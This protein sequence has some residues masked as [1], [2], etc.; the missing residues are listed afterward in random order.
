[1][2]E[3]TEPGLERLALAPHERAGSVVGSEAPADEGVNGP[4]RSI[5]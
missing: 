5:R 3:A 4:E 2:G 1:M